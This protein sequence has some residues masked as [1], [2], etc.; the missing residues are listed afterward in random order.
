MMKS[1]LRRSPRGLDEQGVW[2]SWEGSLGVC[3]SG[4]GLQAQSVRDRHMGFSTIFGF[5]MNFLRAF[6]FADANGFLPYEL[7]LV[8]IVLGGVLVYGLH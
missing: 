6:P 5:P 1:E 8:T 3:S 7:V 2:T 4:T